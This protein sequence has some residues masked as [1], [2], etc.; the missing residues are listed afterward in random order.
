[1][2]NG[3]IYLGIT[4]DDSLFDNVTISNDSSSS[5]EE[6]EMN[7]NPSPKANDSLSMVRSQLKTDNFFEAD[8]QYFNHTLVKGSW[9]TVLQSSGFFIGNLTPNTKYNVYF[10]GSTENPDQFVSHW[11]PV[12][13]LS[14]RTQEEIKF[15]STIG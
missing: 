12:F 6:E 7:N 11:T 1:M 9:A 10:V 5:N 15:E 13:H 3:F 2:N 8:F 14:F 4:T